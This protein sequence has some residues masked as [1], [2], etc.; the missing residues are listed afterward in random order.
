[1]TRSS[2]QTP[3]CRGATKG[4]DSKSGGT[5]LWGP[6]G[7]SDCRLQLFTLCTGSQALSAWPFQMRIEMRHQAKSTRRQTNLTF[8]IQGDFKFCQDVLAC[9][10]GSSSRKVTQIPFR[11][12]NDDM[13]CCHNIVCLDDHAHR[14]NADR[15]SNPLVGPLTPHLL[16]LTVWPSRTGVSAQDRISGRCLMF[17]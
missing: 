4:L 8:G 6:S 10:C 15:T 1:M 17:S 16:I 12:Q 14:K 3:W 13:H 11:G 7:R 5:G 9:C 2:Q